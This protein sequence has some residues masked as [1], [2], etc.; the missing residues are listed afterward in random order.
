MHYQDIIRDYA[1]VSHLIENRINKRNAWF[2]GIGTAFKHIF[3]TLDED[4]AVK[5]D[6]AIA[7]FQDNEKRL[8]SL[9]KE[10]ILVTTSAMSRYNETLYKLKFNEDNLNSAIDNLSLNLKNIS[11]TI[12]D[13]ELKS[14]LNMALN[15]LETITLSLSFQVEDL[16]NSILFS[17]QN[18]LHP[19]IVTPKE[20]YREIVDNIKYLPANLEL[21]VSLELGLV[22]KILSISKVASYFRNNKIIFVVKIPLVIATEYHLYHSIALPAP[23]N[24]TE[25]KSFTLIVPSSKYIGITKD[26]SKYCKM[27]TKNQCQ[28]VSEQFFICDIT[29]EY[30]TDANPCCESD[31]ISK[32]I[33]EIPKTCVTKF[34][35]GSVDIW[36]TLI[37]NKWLFIQ[38][39]PTKLTIECNTA[40][41]IDLNIVGTGILNLPFDCTAYCKGTKLI[42]KD[43]FVNFTIPLKTLNLDL[44]N[45]SCCNIDKFEKVASN[46]VPIHLQNINLDEINKNT[47][48]MFNALLDNT[49][50]VIKEPHIVT[51]GPHYSTITILLFVSLIIFIIY[52]VH[53]LCKS[54]SSRCIPQ[55]YNI[56]LH[57]L[58]SSPKTPKHLPKHPEAPLTKFES[59]PNLVAS[60]SS[61]AVT[62]DDPVM[63]I[64]I[65]TPNLPSSA[66][67][68]APVNDSSSKLCIPKDL[69]SSTTRRHL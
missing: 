39:K 61:S 67:N 57:E 31:L 30:T 24:I 3:G 12:E 25:L 60:P 63:K 22:H 21:P 18:T 43:K 20:L 64:N 40:D 8:V 9:I 42:P 10:N 6:E 50:K 44:R 32:A 29:D 56:Q 13:L 45:D 62:A 48:S 26:K 14:K 36:K 37:N 28:T 33:S 49:D 5:Y 35:Y 4:D 58:N 2:G 23:Y 55:S 16:L 1:S 65:S 17:N 34:I 11:E 59:S 38:S 66:T 47:N 52:K 54:G 68:S 41:I 69:P 27:D 46:V 19:A 53:S 7:S 51:Y 15:T